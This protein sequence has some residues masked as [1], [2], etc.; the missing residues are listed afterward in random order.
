MIQNLR[1]EVGGD[2]ESEADAHTT[3][4]ALHRCAEELVDLRECSD[5]LEVGG[6]SH[7]LDIPRID[8]VEVD[9]LASL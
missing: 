1:V 9:V 7:V 8:A 6:R 2:G 3:A 4:V 5:L